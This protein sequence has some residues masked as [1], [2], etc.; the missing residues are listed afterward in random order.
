MF[1]DCIWYEKIQVDWSGLEV[2]CIVIEYDNFCFI[3]IIQVVY[4]GV[5]FFD[6]VGILEINRRV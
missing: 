6:D 5:E 3:L 2:S 1:W 4:E